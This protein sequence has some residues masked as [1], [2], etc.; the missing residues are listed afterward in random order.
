MRA[1]QIIKG[2]KWTNWTLLLA[3]AMLLKL[4]V[5]ESTIYYSFKHRVRADLQNETICNGKALTSEATMVS[6][7]FCHMYECLMKFK[8]GKAKTYLFS[9]ALMREHILSWALLKEKLRTVWA[10]ITVISVWALVLSTQEASLHK[11]AHL[12]KSPN[13]K[14]IHHSHFLMN[15]EASWTCQA[16]QTEY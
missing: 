6:N 2:D 8:L 4:C 9:L 5:L 15:M 3:L 16:F 11:G 12:R 7:Y 13:K 1:D 10:L 14:H